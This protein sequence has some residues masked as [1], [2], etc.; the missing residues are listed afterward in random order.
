MKKNNRLMKNLLQKLQ[1]DLKDKLSLL[2]EEYPFTAHRIIKDLEATD[3][4]YDVTFLT[5]ATMQK[6]LGVNLDDFYFIF[7][8]DVERG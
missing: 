3:N 4:V 6:F 2:N 1:P 8:P 5:M 7:E